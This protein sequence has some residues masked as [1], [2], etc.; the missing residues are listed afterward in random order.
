MERQRLYIIHGLGNDAVGLVGSITGPIGEAGGNVVDL[1][2]D[3]LH[4]LFTCHLVVDLSE[5][6]LRLAE[7]SAMVARIAEDTG[8]RMTVDKYLPVP[9][10]PGKKNLLVILLGCDRP[11]LIA[12]ASEL[13]G[14]YRANIELAQT[15]GREGMFLMELMTDVSQ[16]RVPLPN[17]MASIEQSMSAMNLT[18]LFQ[19]EDVFNRQKR[20]ILFEVRGSF[21]EPALRDEIVQQTKLEPAGVQAAYLGRAPEEV[22]RKA[23]ALLEGLGIDVLQTIVE[24]VNASRGTLELLQTLKMMGYRIALASQGTSLLTDHLK[25]RLGLDHGFGV[26]LRVDDDSRTVLGE[27]S[28]EDLH[29]VAPDR[30]VAEVAAR[31]GI[32]ADAV[33]VISDAGQPSAPGIRLDFDLGQLLVLRN[34]RALSPDQLVGLLGAFGVP[35]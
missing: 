33:T 20:V 22:Y 17:L 18:T 12:T 15:I 35:R 3:V 28:T 32:G 24:G 23:V 26:P 27:A 6:D 2:Q 16:C 14:R 31:E 5:T 30:V 19:T 8:L 25:Q 9:R 10:S 29:A 1:R 4:G 21:I 11:G 34:Q 13:L 7:L